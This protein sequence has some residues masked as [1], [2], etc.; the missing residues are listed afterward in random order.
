MI[1]DSLSLGLG[2][3]IPIAGAI[4]E[5]LNCNPDSKAQDPASEQKYPGFP[6]LGRNLL[7]IFFFFWVHQNGQRKERIINR[8]LSTVRCLVQQYSR[9]FNVLYH[10]MAT[11]FFTSFP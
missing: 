6:N 10:N 1:P 4:P 5:A 9:H 3:Q 11:V 7:R 8:L 2:F